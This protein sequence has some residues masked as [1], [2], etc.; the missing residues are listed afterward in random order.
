MGWSAEQHAHF[1]AAFEDAWLTGGSP[2]R[3]NP[4]LATNPRYRDWFARYIRLA[5]SPFTARRIADMNAE[6]DI[7]PLVP[8]IRPPSLVIVRSDDVWLAPENS[9]YL[10]RHI[11]GAQLLELPGVDHDPWVGDSEPI[12]AAVERFLGRIGDQVGLVAQNT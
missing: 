8:R 1:L 10:A 7:R 2:E 5:A 11:E 6:M 4:G 9:Y 3:R 12:L